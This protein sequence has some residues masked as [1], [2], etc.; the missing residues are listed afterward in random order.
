MIL[1]S[2]D[3]IQVAKKYNWNLELGSSEIILLVIPITAQDSVK[4]S[5]PG[6]MYRFLLA[7]Q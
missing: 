4:I 2:H 1:K 7:D 6:K 3:Q 5:L